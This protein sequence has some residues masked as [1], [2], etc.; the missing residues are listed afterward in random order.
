MQ[1]D[2]ELRGVEP[3]T[4]N[5]PGLV[6]PLVTTSF[7]VQDEGNVNPRFMRSTMYSV[8]CALDM[9]KQ[10]CTL[11]SLE[12]IMLTSDFVVLLVT[13]VLI[14]L[15]IHLYIFYFISGRY[16]FQSGNHAICNIS[17]RGGTSSCRQHR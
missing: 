11:D 1:E 14:C 8:P 3:F 12:Y 9:M 16:T 5:Q 2:Q 7:I 10:V 15:F 17:F 13:D 6:P 4:T